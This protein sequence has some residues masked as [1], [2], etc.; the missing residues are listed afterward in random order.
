VINRGDIY[1]V[2]LESPNDSEASIPHPYVV[3]QDDLFNHSRITTVIACALTT[4]VKRVSMPGNVLLEAGEANLPK[5]SVVEVS[6]ITTIEKTRLGEYIGTLT[7]PRI[8]QILA[9]IRFLQTAYMPAD[10]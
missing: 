4:N 8:A 7:E 1:W 6:K 10:D 9:G 3:V 5:Q 2:Q